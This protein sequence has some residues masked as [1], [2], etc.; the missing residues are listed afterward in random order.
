MPEKSIENFMNETLSGY[1]RENALE[2]AA[3]LQEQEMQFHRDLSFW[4]D[5]IYFIINDQNQ[6]VFCILIDGYEKGSWVI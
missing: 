2:F 5:K 3:Y 4:K 1:T 6:N